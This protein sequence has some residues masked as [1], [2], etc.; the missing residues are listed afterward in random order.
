MGTTLNSLK[1]LDYFTVSTPEF[2]LSQMVRRA[3]MN[4]ATVLRHLKE[5]RE[6]G[7]LEQDPATKFYTIGP[8]SLRLAAVREASKPTLVAARQ[9]MAMQTETVKESMH[10]SLLSGQELRNVAVK[11]SRHH[12]V[13]VSFSRSELLPLHATASGAIMLAYGP[14]RLK[15]QLLGRELLAYSNTTITD[16]H[17][18]LSYVRNVESAGWAESP[19]AREAD[20][21]G[22]SAPIFGPDQMA[23]G[24]IAFAIPQNRVTPA[25]R[26]EILLSIRAASHDITT[27]FGGIAPASF[28]TK[29]DETINMIPVQSGSELE[30]QS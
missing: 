16:P 22:F 28:P 6:Y 4:K 5:L 10:L 27:I 23:I 30:T 29:F 3:N 24:A 12:S 11:E 25:L 2:S 14:I 21:H 19:G 18:I 13:R 9:I 15:D 17:Q 1:L 26:S 8:A 20:V 7:L